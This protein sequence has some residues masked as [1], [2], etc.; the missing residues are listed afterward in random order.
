MTRRNF[1]KSVATVAA[2]FSILPNATTYARNWVPR[3]SGVLVPNPAY[4]TAEYELSFIISQH[5]DAMCVPIGHYRATEL[6]KKFQP[7]P[8]FVKVE[9]RFAL[10]FKDM[11]D[12]EARKPVNPFIFK[13][14]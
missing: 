1:L 11:A 9:D 7:P 4:V 14:V 13:R 2:A 5:P 3:T 8:G 6:W 12:Y 10:R